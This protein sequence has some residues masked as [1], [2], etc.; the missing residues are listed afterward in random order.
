MRSSSQGSDFARSSSNRAGRNGFDP[1]SSRDL[2][3]LLALRKA[4][5]AALLRRRLALHRRRRAAARVLQR[6]ARTSNGGR[7][8]ARAARQSA[9]A[10]RLTALARGGMARK[11]A[12]R[13]RL[14]AWFAQRLVRGRFFSR[15]VARAHRRAAVVCRAVGRAAAVAARRRRAA[16]RQAWSPGV[17]GSPSRAQVAYGRWCRVAQA[18]V[19]VFEEPFAP[20][21]T[22]M[23]MA[24]AP[25]L[26]S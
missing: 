5:K 19:G 15:L 11:L 2:A 22:R 21:P 1:T 25:S 4:F 9:A 20:R 18:G 7:G 3:A 8:A 24:S 14:Q 23:L 13:L 10:V 12:R 26:I 17:C 16:V 6:W